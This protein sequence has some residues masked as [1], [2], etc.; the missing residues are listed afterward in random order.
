[1]SIPFIHVIGVGDYDDYITVCLCV[2]MSVYQ[3]CLSIKKMIFLCVIVVILVN[4]EKDC[5]KIFT[6]AV[7]GMYFE[8]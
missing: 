4:R 2:Y 7:Y 5:T 6:P 8:W 3:I 1:M